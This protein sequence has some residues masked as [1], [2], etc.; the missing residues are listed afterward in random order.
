MTSPSD[1]YVFLAR[2][3]TSRVTR[4]KGRDMVC[5]SFL[6]DGRETRFAIEKDV[7]ERLDR[8]DR[9]SSILKF[10]GVDEFD[11]WG[12]VLEL[13]PKGSVWDFIGHLDDNE[14]VEPEVVYRWVHQ[15][16]EGLAFAHGHGIMHSDVHAANFFLDSELNLKVADWGEASIDDRRGILFYRTTHT[17]PGAW[18]PTIET[19]IFALGS[20]AYFMV[21]KQDLFLEAHYA[22]NKDEI[23]ECDDRLRRFRN[24]EFPSTVDLPILGQVIKK[25]WNREFRDMKELQLAAE[26]E[27]EM[28]LDLANRA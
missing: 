22:K 5:K 4:L 3:H 13:A 17:M 19:E 25:C 12:L 16:T 15:A 7:Y 9:P 23:A 27:K 24:G 14:P 6:P 11:P 10:Y 2:G 20:S 1:D 26:S 8:A 28:V 18:E 21:Q